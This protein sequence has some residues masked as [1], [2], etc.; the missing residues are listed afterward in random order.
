MKVICDD[1]ISTFSII[2][3]FN[4]NFCPLK[5]LELAQ[6]I[7]HDTED[8]CFRH[9]CDGSDKVMVNNVL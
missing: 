3:T 8:G 6:Y 1:S 2:T 5:S 9:D 4:G 7:C